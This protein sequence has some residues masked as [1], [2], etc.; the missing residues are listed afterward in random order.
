MLVCSFSAFPTYFEAPRG[1][2][3]DNITAYP[4]YDKICE[5]VHKALTV[6]MNNDTFATLRMCT[7]THLLLNYYSTEEGMYVF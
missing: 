6:A 1:R 5:M 4:Q 3:Y 7:P 2:I